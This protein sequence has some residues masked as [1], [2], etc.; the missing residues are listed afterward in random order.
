MFS[1]GVTDT[2]LLRRSCWCFCCFAAL[3][4]GGCHPRGYADLLSQPADSAKAASPADLPA[5]L[6]AQCKDGDGRLAD[7]GAAWVSGSLVWNAVLPRHRLLWAVTIGPYYVV[8][9][10]RG[11]FAHTYRVLIAKGDGNGAVHIALRADS[12]R[13]EQYAQFAQALRTQ[14]FEHVDD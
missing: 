11:G 2:L 14:R 1:A 6:L 8:H 10:E 12:G 5:E 4:I 13:F 3:L 9:F 7:P